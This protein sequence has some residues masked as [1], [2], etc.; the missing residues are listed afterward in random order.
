MD[1]QIISVSA[2]VLAVAFVPSLTGGSKGDLVYF[3]ERLA[4]NVAQIDEDSSKIVPQKPAV[5]IVY[6]NFL[7][8]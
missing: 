5:C 6:L 1:H 7:S 2:G 8:L 3:D 4:F